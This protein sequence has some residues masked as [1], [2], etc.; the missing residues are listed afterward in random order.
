MLTAGAF[1]S[2]GWFLVSNLR[3]RS[4]LLRVGLAVLALGWASNVLVISA[5]GGMPLSSVAYR[6]SGQPGVPDA[7]HGGFYRITV[8]DEETH[9][10]FLGDVLPVP[11]LRNVFSPGDL[12]LALGLGMCVAG[13]MA[14]RQ[15]RQNSLPSGS[16]I[17]TW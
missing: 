3:G 13:A 1:A 2:A 4:G 9:L 16:A 14:P 10:R 11:A 5:N 6:A 15:L 8:A 7:G 12:L 17:V